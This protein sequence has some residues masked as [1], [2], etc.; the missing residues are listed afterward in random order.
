MSVT[1]ISNISV[2][3]IN[4]NPNKKPLLDLS[5]NDYDY[6]DDSNED[7]SHVHFPKRRRPFTDNSGR[8]LSNEFY[9]EHFSGVSLK[10]F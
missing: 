8:V 5:K 3:S 7:L 6:L 10:L 1:P 2:K 4:L 9:D